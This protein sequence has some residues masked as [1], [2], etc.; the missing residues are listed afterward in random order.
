LINGVVAF[1]DVDIVKMS[2]D[3]YTALVLNTTVTVS[4]RIL[5][6]SLHPKEGSHAIINAIEVFEILTAES[7]TSLEE[8]AYTISF[9]IKFLFISI[10]GICRAH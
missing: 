3:R 9:L 1:E 6:I 4:G 2:G 5:T 8:G 7:K 10:Q